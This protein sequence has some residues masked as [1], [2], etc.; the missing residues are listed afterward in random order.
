[1]TLFEFWSAFA[2]SEVFLDVLNQEWIERYKLLDGLGP[3]TLH[4][5]D[6]L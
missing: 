2:S 4:R 1:M 3:K 6:L 5:I